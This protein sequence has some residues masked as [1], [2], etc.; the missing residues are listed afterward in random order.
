MKKLLIIL[1]SNL[2]LYYGYGQDCP[3]CDRYLDF[4]YDEVSIQKDENFQQSFKTW[5]FSERF[6][7]EIKNNKR[8]ISLTVPLKGTIL[9]FGGSNES[10]NV[11]ETWQRNQNS[12]EWDFTKISKDVIFTRI[13]TTESRNV[14]LQCIEFTCGA[15]TQLFPVRVYS[16]TS[17]AIYTFSYNRNVL[18]PHL[19]MKISPALED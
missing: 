2:A 7:K 14:W 8:N 10:S 19:Y 13:A 4:I 5:F 15:Q 3:S 6:E 1:L 16:N 9:T 11:W 18:E 12:T 17:E